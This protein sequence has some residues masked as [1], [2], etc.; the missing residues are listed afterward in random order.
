MVSTSAA[1]N[2]G[3]RRNHVALGPKESMWEELAWLDTNLAS[4]RELLYLLCITLHIGKIVG[5]SV[6]DLYRII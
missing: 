6:W 3:S 1:L 2:S 5:E 4:V